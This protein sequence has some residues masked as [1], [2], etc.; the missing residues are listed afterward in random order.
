MIDIN[1]Q[2]SYLQHEILQKHKQEMAMRQM[3]HPISM[4][5]M[6]WK[7]EWTDISVFEGEPYT[8]DTHALE[9]CENFV[10]GLEYLRLDFLKT[11]DMRIYDLLM[12]LMPVGMYNG[13]YE[14]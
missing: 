2:L 10:Q 4:K 7:D 9:F 1:K 5:L 3:S 12:Q 8:P 14:A 13:N 11:Q 6:P